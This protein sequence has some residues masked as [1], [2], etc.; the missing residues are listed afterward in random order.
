MQK[1][2]RAL[3]VYVFVLF[4][5]VGAFFPY[6]FLYFKG[7]GF[8]NAQIGLL[9]ALGPMVM[10]LV[11]PFW[12]WVSDY[13]GKPEKVSLVLALGVSLSLTLLLSG[14]SFFLVFI[15]LGLFNLFY[16][17]LIPIFDCIAISTLKE[18]KT[19]YGQ[20]R[21]L[22]S[23][24]FALTALAVGRV[25]ELTD[26]SISLWVYVFIALLLAGCALKLPRVAF[27][28]PTSEKLKIWVLFK[29]RE[30]LIFLVASALVIGSNAINYTFFPFL[31]K[32]LG[33]GEG[34][35]GLAMSVTAFAEIPFFFYSAKFHQRFSLAKLLLIAFAVTGL[36][37]FLNSVATTP[38][39]LI[40][41]QLLHSVTFG[42]L[43]ST[44]VVYVAKLS[45]DNLRASGQNLFWAATYGFGS[46][47]ANL[48]GGWVYE[49]YSVQSLFGLASLM[50]IGGTLVF[51]F[52]NLFR[53]RRIALDR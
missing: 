48:L 5:G 29:N 24:G 50:A 41:C 26:I 16:S 25:I 12:G 11:Q 20:I 10:M 27:V 37:W 31:F 51:F 23:L 19:S 22:G 9:G 2:T 3:G 6:V 42:L 17:S 53:D 28:K 43:Y 8:S 15:Y 52:G 1:D 47:V 13:T 39:Q 40:G 38:L 30:F 32:E 45:P 44:A 35:L 46:V 14:R 4:M 49:H 34:L 18:S 7:L 21:W 33:G 36:R